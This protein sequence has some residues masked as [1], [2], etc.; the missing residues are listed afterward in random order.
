M[1]S[2]ARNS[3]N[4]WSG[5]WVLGHQSSKQVSDGTQV[6]SISRVL[7]ASGNTIS[8]SYPSGAGRGSQ[9][10][11]T[12]VDSLNRPWVVRVD[13]SLRGQKSY[14]A[15]GGTG[16]TDTLIYGN[17]VT[18]STRVDQGELVSAVHQVLSGLPSNLQANWMSWSAGGL[19]LS[20]GPSAT[21]TDASNDRFD[22]DALQ[23]LAH[24]RTWGLGGELAEQWFT[25]DRWGNRAQSDFTYATNGG[26]AK[27]DELMA[28]A[29]SY[30]AHN[31]LPT[32]VSLLVPGST[33]GGTTQG[34]VSGYVPT[35]VNYDDLGRL[36]VVNAI[37][38]NTAS[39]TNWV[40]DPSGRVTA[41][42]VNG[43]T[44]TFLLDGEG[45][46]FKRMRADGWLQYTLYG[47]NREPLS[48][49]EKTPSIVTMSQTLAQKA[50]LTKTGGLKA[51][52]IGGGPAG[53]YIDSPGAGTVLVVGQAVYFA[54]STDYGTN[55]YWTF[56]DG[57][58]A[59]GANPV[60]TYS[61]TGTYTVSLKVTGTGYSAT[62]VYR[63]FTV[64]VAKPVISS[65]GSSASTIAQGS[66]ATLS[67]SVSGATS[68]ILDNGIGSVYGSSSI[69]VYPAATTTYTLS[70]TNAGGTSTST[71]TVTVVKPP[72]ISNFY[73]S[74]SSIYQGDGSTLFWT[75]NGATSLSIDNGIGAVS[76]SSRVVSPSASTT[77]VLTATNTV[78]GVSITRTASAPITVNPRPTVPTINS[79]TADASAIAAGSGTTLRWNVSNGVG[80]VSVSI[81]NVGSVAQSGSQWVT[82]G[83]SLTYTLTATNTL[84]S[85]KWVSRDVTVTV[86]NRPTISFSASPTSVNVGSSS[87][88]SWSVGN[89]P[90]SVSIDQGLGAVGGSGSYP[91]TPGST[92]TYTMTASNLA[93]SASAS[94]T[95]SVT[96]KPVIVALNATAS[97]I[98]QGASTTLTWSTQGASTLTVNGSSVSGT[99]LLVAPVTTTTYTLVAS[100]SAGTVSATTTVTVVIPEAYQW[101]KTLV[102]GFGT[103]LS[104]ERPDGV[105]YVQGDQVGSPNIITNASGAVVGRSK[106]MPFGERF[107]NSGEKSLRRY[108][109]HEDQDGSAIYMQ[110]RTYLPTYGK[111]AQV[112]PAYDQTKDDPETW[113]LYNYLTNNPVTHTDP[114]GRADQQGKMGE[115]FVSFD[116]IYRLMNGPNG[117]GY[118]QGLFQASNPSRSA[119]TNADGTEMA[120]ASGSDYKPME[121]KS[122]SAQSG[123]QGAGVS[124]I[125]AKYAMMLTGLFGALGNGVDQNVTALLVSRNLD[126]SDLSGAQKA[127]A[128][129]EHAGWV[130]QT[131]GGDYVIQSG[132]KDGQNYANPV[133]RLEPG[134][135]LKAFSQVTNSKG[136]TQTFTVN[137]QA[138]FNV[139]L[140]GSAKDK[141]QG[142]VENWNSK[143][144]RYDYMGP[145]SNTFAHW[146]GRQ[147]GLD[148][149]PF[150]LAHPLPAW[151]Q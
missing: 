78:N 93:G 104:E 115:S 148:P 61:A 22:Y 30:D 87:T 120:S 26:G 133:E 53:A 140:A 3:H 137:I 2:K 110:A 44:T 9:V 7:D 67:W 48:I 116:D 37:P 16:W 88:L 29:S 100:N 60:K 4:P 135:G 51:L 24:A 81:S 106:N 132:P 143:N 141:L 151:G 35:G 124:G 43:V 42:T 125:P 41:E 102:Y 23:R 62:T 68:L 99:S 126:V 14:G 8:L 36:G 84:D 82:P 101:R 98:N 31:G 20:R 144:I 56:G 17:G 112:D 73:A 49:F 136:E 107:G 146:F 13:N 138:S 142:I 89:G 52:A 114:D 111:F 105:F 15:V 122:P 92:T 70:A 109:N 12:D 6:F 5:F 128:Y 32:M 11:T 66:G 46:R 113:N 47:F 69:V 91:V 97:Q 65:F 121:A 71:V 145:N 39:Q 95:I 79:F 129:F 55:Y 21:P 150:S 83:A 90:T 86:V 85:S 134:Q 149:T 25:Y 123:T 76:S 139:S 118:L 147:L 75:V 58:T 131:K 45:L 1:P 28:W 63:T 77:Y 10:V 57:T 19:L 40:Y 94:V 34:T 54:G 80:A 108:T 74:P 38:G 50:N 72:T 127:I 96:Q 18:T 130:I 119:S 103:L 59:T 33:A 27:P 117:P 64:T